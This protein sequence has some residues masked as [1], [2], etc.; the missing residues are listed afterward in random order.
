MNNQWIKD[1]CW[2][3]ESFLKNPIRAV[4][5]SFHG[6]NGLYR[7]ADANEL[8]IELAQRGI[9]IIF[10]YYG[11]W[12]WMNRQARA[13]V[14]KLIASVYQDLNLDDSLPLIASGGSMGG[15]SALLYC[16]YG[17][18]KPIGCEALSP[19]CDTVSHF[20][21]WPDLP[22]SFYHAFLGY[23]EPRRNCCRSTPRCIRPPL[24]RMPPI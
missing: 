19:V 6:L 8:E 14:D 11:P 21:E 1:T 12:S 13:F 17:R 5:L 22:A 16:R 3:N 4:M 20:R 23:P 10:P 15:C 18:K 24:C 9:L 2:T 7:N